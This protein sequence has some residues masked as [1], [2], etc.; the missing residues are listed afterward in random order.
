MFYCITTTTL[1]LQTTTLRSE[2]TEVILGSS[3][4][5]LLVWRRI[6]RALGL[7]FAY[8]SADVNFSFTIII[9]IFNLKFRQLL[10][11]ICFM[12]MP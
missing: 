1:R 10:V 2:C 3:L 9:E 4:P 7:A 12:S 5:L 6:A 11:I 8:Q